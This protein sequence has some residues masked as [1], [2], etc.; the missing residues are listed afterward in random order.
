MIVTSVHSSLFESGR[1][2][3]GDPPDR[4]KPPASPRT[5]RSGTLDSGGDE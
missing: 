3:L 1:D 4:Y 2:Y 5:P